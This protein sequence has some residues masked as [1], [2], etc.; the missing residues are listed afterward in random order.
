MNYLLNRRKHFRTTA[1]AYTMALLHCNGVDESQTF[2]DSSTYER[3]VTANGSVK[4]DT[5][6]YKFGGAAGYF[7][8][9]TDYLTMADSADWYFGTGDFSLDFWIRLDDITHRHVFMAQYV[10]GGNWWRFQWNEDGTKRLQHIISVAGDYPMILEA[11]WTPVAATWYHVALVRNGNNWY[12]FV[13]GVDQS[14][15]VIYG[16]ATAEMPDYASTLIIGTTGAGT[17]NHWLAGFMDEARISK[18]IAR[19]TS[20]FTPPSSEY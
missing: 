2:T 17:A 19:W 20:N 3:T 6:Q 14:A 10:D 5:A 16:S 18:G 15:A 11:A 9:S 12:M 1:D 4:I 13:G 8:G 7:N